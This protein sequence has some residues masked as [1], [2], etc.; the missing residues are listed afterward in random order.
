MNDGATPGHRSEELHGP[1]FAQCLR[2]VKASSKAGALAGGTGAG[3]T[4]A[5][6][7]AAQSDRKYQSA[8]PCKLPKGKP[9]RRIGDFRRVVEVLYS[10]ELETI[11]DA[12][13]HRCA[14]SIGCRLNMQFGAFKTFRH[15]PTD[16]CPGKLRKLKS[17]ELTKRVSGRTWPCRNQ[18]V[19]EWD[20]RK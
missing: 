20:T 19:R 15:E 8:S 3:D 16:C 1:S 10:V 5:L 7:G 6:C 13:R 2:Q 11:G 18:A 14:N 4:C 9:M 12:C 17:A